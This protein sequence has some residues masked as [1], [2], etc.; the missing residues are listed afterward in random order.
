MKAMSKTTSSAT[1]AW[2]K[3]VAKPAQRAL[4]AAGFA[5]VDQLAN[6]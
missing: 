5:N 3:G 2:P 6:A 4:A 1:E